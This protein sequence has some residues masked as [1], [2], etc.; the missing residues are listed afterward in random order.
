MATVLTS[1]NR[2]QTQLLVLAIDNLL[3]S[4]SLHQELE[5]LQETITSK[6]LLVKLVQACQCALVLLV[7]LV[8]QPIVD[9]V[10]LALRK[11]SKIEWV[12]EDH[13][14]KVTHSKY[15]QRDSSSST[16]HKLQTQ[17]T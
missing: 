4:S 3:N 14:T 7:P 12:E 10:Q 15:L 8:S 9:K 17:A 13:T 16:F 6:H 5:W 11:G 1:S 2:T